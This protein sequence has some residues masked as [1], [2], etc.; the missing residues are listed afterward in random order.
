MLCQSDFTLLEAMLDCSA[1]CVP[2]DTFKQA[3]H[4]WQF[5]PLHIYALAMYTYVGRSSGL[6]N[7]LKY[8]NNTLS[9][10]TKVC[11]NVYFVVCPVCVINLNGSLRKLNR[12]ASS[13]RLL[14]PPPL[15]H[16]ADRLPF[17]LSP[18]FIQTCE[19]CLPLFSSSSRFPSNNN[20]VN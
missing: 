17:N 10:K 12:C 9:E 5:F 16:G 2:Y 7:S 19:F 6:F 8:L 3:Q 20:L 15:Q 11:L 18:T 4:S 14:D 13:L 1:P